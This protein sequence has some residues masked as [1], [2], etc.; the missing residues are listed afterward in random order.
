MDRELSRSEILQYS[1][2][3]IECLESG[4]VVSTGT[5]F[6]FSFCEELDGK[7]VPAIV[8]NKHVV[9]GSKHGRLILTL[10]NGANLPSDQRFSFDIYNF[11]NRWIPHPDEDIDLCVLLIGPILHDLEARGSNA[12]R[13][14]LEPSLI[15]SDTMKGSLVALED[16]LMIGYPNGLWDSV[17]NLPIMR[18]GVTATHPNRDYNGAKEFMIDAACFPGSSGS[19]VF[20]Y[21]EG[22]YSDAR[23]NLS[24]GSRLLLLGILYAGPQFTA[25]GDIH[26]VNI[27]TNNKHIV[28]SSI[29]N[30]LGIVIKSEK[31]LDFEPVIQKILKT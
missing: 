7:N 16:I 18:K 14:T 12:F 30:N 13:A 11:E 29:P 25:Q 9:K 1:T 17:N 3:R 22:A 21:N 26:V 23:G 2:V 27:P 31:L 19:P 15:P 10:T 5:G 28:L 4:Q 6:F 24:V 20:L 8:T